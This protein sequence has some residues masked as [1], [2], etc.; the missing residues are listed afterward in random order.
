MRNILE[1]GPWGLGGGF[2]GEV[3]EV[4]ESQTMPTFEQQEAS[5]RP[6]LGPG[7]NGRCVNGDHETFQIIRHLRKTGP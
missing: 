6:Q 1:D 5:S 2:G 4:D 7:V 3:R